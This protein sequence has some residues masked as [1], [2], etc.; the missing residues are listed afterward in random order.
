M[1]ENIKGSL[2]SGMPGS[3]SEAWG[4]F[5]DGLGSNIMVLYS[6]GPIIT[7]HG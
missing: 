1:L 5:Y 6:V 4:M 3:D 7:L 2:Q